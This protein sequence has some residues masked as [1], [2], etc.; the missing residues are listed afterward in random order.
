[1]PARD[2][3]I[4]KRF[5]FGE[6]VRVSWTD[7]HGRYHFADAPCLDVSETGMQIELNHPLDQQ[8]YVNIRSERYGLNTNARVRHVRQ[9][10]MKYRIGLQFHGMWRWK[11]LAG[12][13]SHREPSIEV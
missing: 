5:P 11:G 3:R 8:C 2:R 6:K 7:A 4:F 9:R 10:G 12:I 1:M 13:L